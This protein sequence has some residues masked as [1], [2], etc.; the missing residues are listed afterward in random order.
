MKIIYLILFLNIGSIRSQCLDNSFQLINYEPIVDEAKIYIFI[1]VSTNQPNMIEYTTQCFEKL[2]ITAQSIKNKIQFNFS[3]NF[4]ASNSFQPYLLDKLEPLE[5]YNITLA[6]KIKNKNRIFENLPILSF[7][8]FGTPQEANN[9][10]AFYNKTS[11]ILNWEKPSTINSPDICYYLIV[12]RFLDQSNGI[13]YQEVNNSY[14]FD[15]N[16]L[17]RNFEVRI[18]VVN[19][20]K[21][22]K[23]QY[24]AAEKCKEQQ[25]LIRTS[26]RYVNYIFKENTQNY[27]TKFKI[28]FKIYFTILIFSIFFTK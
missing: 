14:S 7:T 23:D 26:S 20:Y 4:N 10:T 13:E 8:C 22:Y 24:L 3:I 16:D 1:K 21:C 19:D 28:S 15:D 6:Y 18:S 25:N 2:L 17:K 9:L 11:L 5:L 27:S 12:K